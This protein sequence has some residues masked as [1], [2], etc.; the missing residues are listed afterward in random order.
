M[1]VIDNGSQ[2]ETR[3]SKFYKNSILQRTPDGYSYDQYWGKIDP[4]VAGEENDILS[5][6]GIY[7]QINVNTL[8]RKAGTTCWKP[9]RP[10]GIGKFQGPIGNQSQEASFR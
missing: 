1:A 7:N 9:L 10:G 6:D 8:R 3:Y 2:L 4:L 5:P